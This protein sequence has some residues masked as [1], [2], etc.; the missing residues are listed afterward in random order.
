MKNFRLIV[1]SALIFCAAFSVKGQDIKFGV[2]GTFQQN[3]F[4]AK[5]NKMLDWQS[6]YSVGLFGRYI[7]DDQLSFS[8]EPTFAKKGA[9]NVDYKYF[10]SSESLYFVDPVSGEPYD[11][12][13][14][15]T[16]NSVIEMP[17]LAHFS[18]GA[19]RVFAGPSFDLILKS[20]FHS[21]RQDEVNTGSDQFKRVDDISDRVAKLDFAAVLGVAYDLEISSFD[22]S[23]EASYKH[24]FSDINNVENKPELYTNSF[25]VG[26]A[27]G[28]NRLI[29]GE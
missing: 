18:L 26:V 25:S 20:E 29:L 14:M 11:M 8:F 9:N 27:V 4:R 16:V 28:L 6:G 1:A 7:L 5:E 21:L 12:E 10:Y 15:H 22:L 19:L 17:V 3:N 24:G 23:I 2:K 13:Y